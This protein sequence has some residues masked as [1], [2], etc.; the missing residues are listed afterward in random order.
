MVEKAVVDYIRQNHD[1]YDLGAIKHKILGSG[2]SE[3]D[4][5]EALEELGLED[6]PIQKSP[7]KEKTKERVK[8]EIRE[9]EEDEIREELSKEY[10]N[11]KPEAENS[12]RQTSASEQKGA[13][14]MK[15]GGICGLAIML[16]FLILAALYLLG[17][18]DTLSSTTYLI[19]VFSSLLIIFICVLL[20]YFGFYKLGKAAE[21][22]AL[23][24]SSMS[25]IVVLILFIILILIGSIMSKSIISDY[26]QNSIETGSLYSLSGGVGP[27]I[28][29]SIFV[30]VW[31]F[32][33]IVQILFSVG[34]IKISSQVKFAKITGILNLILTLIQILTF[35]A[36]IYLVFQ[37]IANPL[38]ILTLISSISQ[39]KTISTI[40]SI[41]TAIIGS[42]TFLLEIVVLF[43]GS[44]QFEK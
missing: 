18:L 6:K 33:I 30:L 5:S 7:E 9:N 39:Y 42:L 21:S 23:K 35:I 27:I 36:S 44:K 34:L 29:L 19:I 16:L 40:I 1:K 25:I 17:V 26:A 20:F 22:R 10:G 28:I 8:E 14:W 38:Y 11:Y 32:F 41:S 3:Q 4:I 43:Y 2:Y 13:K 37:I 31:L 15:I 24:F 12:E